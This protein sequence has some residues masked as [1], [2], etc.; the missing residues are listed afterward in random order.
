MADA[1]SLL[2]T[3][4][5]RSIVDNSQKLADAGTAN[6][7]AQ[8]NNHARCAEVLSKRICEYDGPEAMATA[9]GYSRISP[10]SQGYHAANT[11]TQVTGAIQNNQNQVSQALLQLMTSIEG[12]KSVMAAKS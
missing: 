4:L 10:T 9:E 5:N 12:L 3:S 6:F 2:E 11:M 8:Q 7:T 1:N